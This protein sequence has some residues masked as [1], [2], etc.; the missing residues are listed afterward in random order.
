MHTPDSQNGLLKV[1]WGH[2]FCLLA[3][4]TWWRCLTV[5]MI[6]QPIMNIPVVGWLFIKKTKLLA[7]KSC[8][9]SVYPPVRI[10]CLEHCQ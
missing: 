2:I 6:G 10:S 1:M 7:D 5:P 8:L 9:P 3:Y 4:N